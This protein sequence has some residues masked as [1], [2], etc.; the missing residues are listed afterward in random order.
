MANGVICRRGF[1]VGVWLAAS[2]VAAAGEMSD[3]ERHHSTE[4]NSAAY[5]AD[6]KADGGVK[7][8]FIGNSITL[9]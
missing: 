6:R 8:L 3:A 9:H 2:A 5:A 7:V 1:L 4:M